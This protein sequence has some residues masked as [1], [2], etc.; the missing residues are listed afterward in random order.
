MRVAFYSKP[1][2]ELC[3]RSF[4]YL[5]KAYLGFQ[6]HSLQ[7]FTCSCLEELNCYIC[8]MKGCNLWFFWWYF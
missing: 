2:S 8:I 3:S 7:V 5:L 4:P 6:D 1:L